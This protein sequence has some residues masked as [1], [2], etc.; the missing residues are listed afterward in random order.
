MR[1]TAALLMFLI[2][3][4]AVRAEE[5]P[6]AQVLFVC[7]HGNVKSLM[8]ASYFN[9]LAASRGLRLRAVSRGSAPDSNTVPA[10]IVA[11]LRTDGVDV[12]DFRPAAV[13]EAD[14]A[15]SA[16]IVAISTALPSDVDAPAAKVE[17]WDDVP[18]ASVN[19]WAARNSLKAH[20][21][22]LL[23]RMSTPAK[24]RLPLKLEA[25]IPL[26]NVDGRIDHLA[27]DL[28]RHRLFVAELGNGTVGVVSIESREVERRLTGFD[29]P[30][31]IAYDRSTD[32]L[33]V[34]SGGDGTLRMF[35][36]PELAPAGTI[37]LGA[38][39]DNVR[40]DTDHRIAYV[41]YGDG[42]L[43]A[44]DMTTQRKVGDIALT[45]HPEGFQLERAGP[46][47]F[48][49][50]PQVHAIA[51][52]DRRTNRQI[53]TWPTNDLRAN[54]PMAVDH[55]RN[56]VLL[57]FRQPPVLAAFDATDGK[58]LSETVACGDT[59]D[60]F[61]DPKRG[62]IYMSCGEGFIDVFAEQEG[63]YSRIARVETT[64]GARTALF[65]AEL[66]RLFLAVRA[67]G[68]EPA[69]VWVFKPD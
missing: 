40:L 35:R 23:E 13:S 34:A 20:V 26:G 36:G 14:V 9:Q 37:D 55:T 21:E 7:E 53:A 8:A 59:D 65:S 57:G 69:A 4:T 31:G 24:Q 22:Q 18:A 49:N 25:K 52:L 38:D 30:Q 5:P 60:V 46:R 62:Y 58:L 63:K 39:A 6:A 48:V 27:V 43:A 11:G 47:I 12:S 29:E 1:T 41:G 54:Y 68:H 64:K 45:A 50:V 56:R 3:C 32:T 19:Y 10:P 67:G 33:Y 28:D 61:V 2:A 66:D 44:I 17:R 15:A 16:R 51:V 42:A